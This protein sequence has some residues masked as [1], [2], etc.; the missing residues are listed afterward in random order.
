[1][2]A[3]STKFKTQK[4]ES[5]RRI[6]FTNEFTNGKHKRGLHSVK[7]I[8]NFSLKNRPIFEMNKIL[9]RKTQK[10]DGFRSY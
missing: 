1:M 9:V 4:E 6:I 5:K 8:P 2:R 3:T 10:I 7:K